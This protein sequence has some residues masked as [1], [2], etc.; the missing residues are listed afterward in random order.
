M[1]RFF[2]LLGSFSLLCCSLMARGEA[3]ARGEGVRGNFDQSRD[4]NNRNA[5]YNPYYYQG[6]G[7]GPGYYSYP[8]GY[9]NHNEN[10]DD[11]MDQIYRHNQ[12]SMESK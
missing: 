1:L 11:D 2:I 8:G 4:F 12:R 6:E 7:Y 3:G 5:L 9:Y 10:P